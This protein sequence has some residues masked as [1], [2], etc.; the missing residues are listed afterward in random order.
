MNKVDHI[1]YATPDLELGMARIEELLGVRPIAGGKHPGY[2]TRN[3]LLSLGDDVYLEIIGPDPEQPEPERSRV[4][5]VDEIES[6]RLTTWVAKEDNLESRIESAAKGGLQFG[7]ILSGGRRAPDGSFLAWRVS[8]PQVV[9]GDGVV[10]FLIDWGETPHPATTAP[11]GGTLLSL[12]AEHPDPEAV[13]LLLSAAGL[14][15]PLESGPEPALIATVETPGGR[16][17]LR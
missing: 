11:R 16:A 10:P 12:R 14:D 17:E 8:D 9:N 5:R 7:G 4:F 15:L 13:R 2:G 6:P 1:I 3:A